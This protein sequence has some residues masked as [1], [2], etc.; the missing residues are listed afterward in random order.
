LLLRLHCI[1]AKLAV[2]SR[3][4]HPFLKVRGQGGNALF[5]ILIAVALF[6]ALAYAVTQSGRSGGGSASREQATLMGAQITSAA[7]MIRQTVIRMNI[8]GIAMDSI[9]CEAAPNGDD[10]GQ[11][12]ANGSKDFCT[13]GS[14]CIFAPD[15]GGLTVPVVPQAAYDFSTFGYAATRF[16][17]PTSYQGFAID[18]FNGGG[19]DTSIQDIGTAA[20]DEIVIFLGLKREVCEAIDRG[21][22]IDTVPDSSTWGA[23]PGPI[24]NAVGDQECVYI[25][26]AFGLGMNY[27]YYMVLNAN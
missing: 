24:P 22:G 19:A 16:A 10:C 26:N 8:G 5:L 9:T 17:G 11:G 20:N 4:T 18:G 3:A 6:A 13:T 25:G 15:G 14:T 23:G 12:S 27:A 1:V 21:L 7:T 2:M